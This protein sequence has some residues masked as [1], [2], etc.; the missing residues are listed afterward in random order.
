MIK[1]QKYIAVPP[2][3]TIK[4]QLEDRG[5]SRE[6]FAKE[7]GM[8]EA[9]VSELISGNIPL[10]TETAERLEAVLGVPAGFWNKMEAFYRE[11]SRKES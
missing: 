4:E 8:S 5:M 2:G 10:T 11:D 7:M 9:R 3:A 6:E 1:R